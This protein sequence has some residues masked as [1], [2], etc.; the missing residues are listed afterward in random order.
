MEF[1]PRN[2]RYITIVYILQ[3]I[4]NITILQYITIV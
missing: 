4:Q 1:V 2:N 3:Y